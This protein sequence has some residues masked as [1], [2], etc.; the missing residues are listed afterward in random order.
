MYTQLQAKPRP[1]NQT[2]NSIRRHRAT[3]TPLV[4][5]VQASS[6]ICTPFRSS[7]L[8]HLILAVL[9]QVLKQVASLE[10]LIGMNNRL[11]LT[12]RHDALILGLPNL[13]LVNM[14]KNPI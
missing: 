14:F 11:Q 8:L 10:I 12:R 7:S 2:K 6:S 9:A 1:M 5:S 13:G 4:Y 3:S